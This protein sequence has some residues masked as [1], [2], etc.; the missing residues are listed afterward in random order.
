MVLLDTLTRPHL[1]FMARS[2][3]ALGGYPRL[4]HV[5]IDA[6]QWAGSYRVKSGSCMTMCERGTSVV[7]NMETGDLQSVRSTFMSSTKEEGDSNRGTS[8]RSYPGAKNF[9]SRTRCD[10]TGQSSK[11]TTI[12]ADWGHSRSREVV[13]GCQ[14]SRISTNL[15]R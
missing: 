10:G 4:Q 7:A 11:A 1:C 5:R 2:C 14:S 13:A 15:Y 8:G 6:Y 12:S 3:L 9:M